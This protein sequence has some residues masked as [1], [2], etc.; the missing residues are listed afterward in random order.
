MLFQGGAPNPV[1]VRDRRRDDGLRSRPAPDRFYYEVVPNAPTYTVNIP[2]DMALEFLGDGDGVAGQMLTA[3]NLPV[4]Y[5]R[6]QLW[7]ATRG[8]DA[9]T[10]TSAAVAALGAQGDDRRRSPASP[11]ATRS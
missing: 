6:Q 1:L 11:T 5:G 4:Y 9:T 2:M 10:T 8:R 7:E 3:G